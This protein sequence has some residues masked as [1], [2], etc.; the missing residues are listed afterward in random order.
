LI[1]ITHVSF[2]TLHAVG[3]YI[4]VL[5]LIVQLHK[6]PFVFTPLKLK[7]HV[8]QFHS[9]ALDSATNCAHVIFL[10]VFQIFHVAKLF[11]VGTTLLNVYVAVALLW[12]PSASLTYHVTVT[13]H[14]C[15]AAIPVL[16][17]VHQLHAPNL[18]ALLANHTPPLSLA[19]VI[20]KLHAVHSFPFPLLNVNV[21]ASLSIFTVSLCALSAFPNPSLL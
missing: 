1:V 3:V 16:V 2:P 19:F 6:L 5:L 4:N 12:F 14:G 13:L 10:V 18:Y 21:G 20:L 8:P 17:A 11:A 7:F 9:F 15:L